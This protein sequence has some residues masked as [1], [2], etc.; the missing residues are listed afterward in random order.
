MRMGCPGRTE[1]LSK[2]FAQVEKL[3]DA[4]KRH[5][6]RYLDTILKAAKSGKG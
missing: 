2:R 5:V 6:A 1:P 3:P 4:D